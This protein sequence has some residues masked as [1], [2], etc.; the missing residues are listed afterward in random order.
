MLIN[1]RQVKEYALARATMRS[2]K[3]TRV[4]KEFYLWANS[5]LC[6]RIDWYIQTLPSKG[7]TIK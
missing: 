1:K 4:S 3:F 7:R 5:E 2:H 6:R